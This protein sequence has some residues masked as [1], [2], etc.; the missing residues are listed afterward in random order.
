MTN[1]RVGLARGAWRLASSALGLM[2]CALPPKQVGVT[3][4]IS[5]SPPGALVLVSERPGFFEKSAHQLGRTPLMHWI[6]MPESEEWRVQ[7][8]RRGCKEWEG[9]PSAASPTISARLASQHQ[10]EAPR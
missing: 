6:A 5:S 3:V 4:R 2:A 10:A 9:P 7:I 1:R 8:S